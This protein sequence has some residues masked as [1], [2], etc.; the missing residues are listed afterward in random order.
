MEFDTWKDEKGESLVESFVK[1]LNKEQRALLYDK[2]DHYKKLKVLD[3]M[4]E[5]T[6]EKIKI[7]S[8]EKVKIYELKFK[9]SPPIRM[10]GTLKENKYIAYHAFFKK[11]NGPIKSREIKTALKRIS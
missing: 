5:K 3:L 9:Q 4:R 8:S 11:N 2:I 10:I 7:S 1:I 6:L